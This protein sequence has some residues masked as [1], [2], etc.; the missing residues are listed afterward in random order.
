MRPCV[1]LHGR[2]LAG[3]RL[4]C[5]GLRLTQALRDALVDL[6]PLFIGG[7]DLAICRQRNAHLRNNGGL[8]LHVALAALGLA[9]H[10]G[11]L[12]GRHLSQRVAT[13][14]ADD[15]VR[16]AQVELVQHGLGAGLCLERLAVGLVDGSLVLQLATADLAHSLSDAGVAGVI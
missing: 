2:L 7:V 12:G 11:L 4:G 14:F 13:A 8:G 10:L 9:A 15:L 16:V 1:R 6:V 3:C 5:I